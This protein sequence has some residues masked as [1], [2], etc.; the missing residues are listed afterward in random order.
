MS[1]LFL[2]LLA[3]SLVSTTAHAQ[4]GGPGAC[5]TPDSIIVRGNQRVSEATIR[6]AAGLAAGAELNYRV[7][8]RALKDLYATTEFD[9]VRIVCAPG[10]E[11]KTVLAIEVK[12][13]PILG[14]IEVTGT[15]KVSEKS[16]RDKIEI[17]T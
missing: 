13:R 15:D 17:P 9:D 7:I 1:R 8:Q 6:G 2:S 16:V 11:N 4:T 5:S 12:E 3:I 10:P 14:Q